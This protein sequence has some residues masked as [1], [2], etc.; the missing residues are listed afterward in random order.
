ME[1]SKENELLMDL[2]IATEI[3]SC[4]SDPNHGYTTLFGRNMSE[5][6]QPSSGT[7][8]SETFGGGG[9]CDFPLHT[10]ESCDFCVVV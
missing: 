3:I 6:D 9:S 7:W 2:L 10:I 4:S 8:F 5:Y 1:Y